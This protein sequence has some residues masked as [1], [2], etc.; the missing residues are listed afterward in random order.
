MTVTHQNINYILATG[1]RCIFQFPEQ[2][3]VSAERPVCGPTAT[4][5]L[6]RL[7]DR[8]RTLTLLVFASVC[9]VSD[10]PRPTAYGMEHLPTTATPQYLRGAGVSTTPSFRFFEDT[11]QNSG[12]RIAQSKELRTLVETSRTMIKGSVGGSPASISAIDHHFN[13]QLLSI[14]RP[15]SSKKLSLQCN[16]WQFF[17]TQIKIEKCYPILQYLKSLSLW[18]ISNSYMLSL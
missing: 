5:L 1:C 2:N 9:V 15:L 6:Y 7:L 4:L 8:R 14:L 11:R 13:N 12:R 18:I 17:R 16:V 3:P 10:V